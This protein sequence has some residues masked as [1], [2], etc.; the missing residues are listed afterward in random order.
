MLALDP[1]LGEDARATIGGIVA[2]GDSGPLRHRYGSARDLV[3]GMTVA[4]SDG[5]V[6]QSGGKVIKNVAGLRPGQAVHRLVRHAR[7]DPRAVGAP[8]PAVARERHRRRALRR[9][10]RA[11]RA[12]R[13]ALSHARIEL[14]SLDVRW[15]DG[16]GR[17]AG[18]L[19]RRGRG[20]A[21]GGRR[22]VDDG[23][24]GWRLEVSDDDAELWG[25]QREAQRSRGRRG[26]AGLGRADPAR[27]RVL[28]DG[29]ARWARGSSGARGW[30]C[31]GS[32]LPSG[33]AT[34]SASRELRRALAPSPCVVLD[35]PRAA[36]ARGRLGRARPGRCGRAART[37][38]LRPRGRM[39]ARLDGSV[40]GVGSITGICMAIDPARRDR[41][42]P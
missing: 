21:G 4:L 7:R 37:R 8:A 39:C 12:P 22:R 27:R 6:A 3:V 20:R 41:R 16:V 19:R 1:P 13:S 11:G 2:T 10:A 26:G 38:A 17:G 15:E 9:P 5:T 33:S 18:A 31:R 30:A 24:M 25:A 28:R 36:R 14:Q 23:A 42:R 34:P 32:T 29:A 40:R 35:A